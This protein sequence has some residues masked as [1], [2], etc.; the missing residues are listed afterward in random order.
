MAN[1][2]PN[3]YRKL[4]GR[5]NLEL[6][7]SLYGGTERDPLVLL[8]RVG[9]ADAVDRRVGTY[10]KGMQMRLNFVRVLIHAP[11]AGLAVATCGTKF[12]IRCSGS[13]PSARS[14]WLW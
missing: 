8:E 12:E 11:W 6:F 1:E 14:H 7:G 13:Q 3:H 9:V 10:S 5:E 4:T 2:T